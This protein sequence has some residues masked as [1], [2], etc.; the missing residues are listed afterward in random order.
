MSV[1][2]HSTKV[3]T[4]ELDHAYVKLAEVRMHY[5]RAGEGPPIQSWR[6]SRVGHRLDIDFGFAL[7]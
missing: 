5:V 7:G 4:P 3:A 1:P 2:R 6:P